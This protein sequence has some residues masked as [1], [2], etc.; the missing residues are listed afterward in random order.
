MFIDKTTAMIRVMKQSKARRPP[1]SSPWHFLGIIFLQLVSIS[2]NF[3]WA[4]ASVKP[5]KNLALGNIEPR[6]T[7]ENKIETTDLTR[8]ILQ[9]NHFPLDETLVFNAYHVTV[10]SKVLA[11]HC[12]LRTLN[13]GKM[14]NRLVV[15][16]QM[17]AISATWYS[18]FFVIKNHVSGYFDLETQHAYYLRINKT[19]NTYTQLKTIQFDYAKMQII[20][21]SITK[22]KLKYQQ[23]LAPQ[24]LFDAYSSLFLVRNGLFEPGRMI[25][26]PVYANGEI[27]TLNAK[28]LDQRQIEIENKRYNVFKVEIVTRF[29]GSMEQAGGIFVYFTTDSY[30]VP[31]LI[32]ADVKVGKFVLEIANSPKTLQESTK[33]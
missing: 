1:A 3:G 31:I 22:G 29:E 6:L 30:H 32:E 13:L 10:V 20:E 27:H 15:R 24:K 33:N 5:L 18:W 9:K 12:Y 2:P 16:Y 17:D 23:Y 14:A 11:G 19:E 8:K 7:I 25:T 4:N 21:K 28:V 26:Y